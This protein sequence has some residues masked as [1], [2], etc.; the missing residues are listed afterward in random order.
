MPQRSGTNREVTR[1]PYGTKVA[2]IFSACNVYNV[3]EEDELAEGKTESDETCAGK[4]VG[5]ELEAGR[6]LRRKAIM[7]PAKNQKSCHGNISRAGA[8]DT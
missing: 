4:G 6:L 1:A 5:E 3:K 2:V 7:V 8:R